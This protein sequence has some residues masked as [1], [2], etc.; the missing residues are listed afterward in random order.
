MALK[1]TK[2]A[3]GD[4]GIYWLV[5]GYPPLAVTCV[6]YLWRVGI[7]DKDN[8]QAGFR[9]VTNPLVADIL[10]MADPE[11]GH[12]WKWL[13]YHELALVKFRSRKQSLGAIEEALA[14]EPLPTR[15]DQVESTIG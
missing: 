4:G 11:R 2:A 12:I 7:Y 3:R 10:P 8:P 15:V 14:K 5:V 6:G 1:V 13:L 9:M